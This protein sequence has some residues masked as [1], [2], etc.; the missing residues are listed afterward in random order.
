VNFNSLRLN[1][2]RHHLYKKNGLSKETSF[3][4]PKIIFEGFLRT[5]VLGFQ[6]GTPKFY[7]RQYEYQNEGI[8]GY[9]AFL[10]RNRIL[11]A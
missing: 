7:Y 8:G 2:E 4:L 6:P 1:I 11:G 5:R 3:I 9:S 10:E